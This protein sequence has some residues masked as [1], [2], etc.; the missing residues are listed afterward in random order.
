MVMKILM[1]QRV[2]HIKLLYY[3]F[4]SVQLKWLSRLS[5]CLDLRIYGLKTQFVVTIVF[6]YVMVAFDNLY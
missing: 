5:L 2:V 6:A 3:I 1:A 4:S